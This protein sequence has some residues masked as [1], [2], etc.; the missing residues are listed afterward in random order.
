MEI[1]LLICFLPFIILGFIIFGAFVKLAITILLLP[2]QG[3][4]DKKPNPEKLYR[5]PYSP[6]LPPPS[7]TYPSNWGSISKAKKEKE[8]WT[9]QKCK[10]FLGRKEHKRLLQVHHVNRNPMDN[11]EKN[12]LALC[13]VCHSEQPGKGHKR[14]KGAI[15]KDGRWNLIHTIRKS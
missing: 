8:F 13:L 6:P 7:D 5:K 14:L 3:I 1:I 4:G 11:N 15:I 10:V 9:C 2:F 12:L